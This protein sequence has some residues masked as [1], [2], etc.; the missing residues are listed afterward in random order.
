MILSLLYKN[1]P[2]NLKLIMIDPKMIEFSIYNDIPHLLTPVITKP[3][4]A[5][6]ALANMVA[7]MEKRYVM[8]AESKTKNIDNYNEKSKNMG[9]EEMPYI[10]IVIDELADLMMTSG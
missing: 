9:K 10:V 4:E 2:D 6:N 8:M 7:E 1:S 5:I 3:T